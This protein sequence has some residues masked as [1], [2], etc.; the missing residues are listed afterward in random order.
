LLGLADHLEYLGCQLAVGVYVV[1][2]VEID[3]VDL[4]A[5]GAL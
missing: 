3:G 5:A 4:F 2:R 1:G